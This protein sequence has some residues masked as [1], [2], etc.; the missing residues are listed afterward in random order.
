MRPRLA[1]ERGMTL[2]EVMVTMVI[3]LIMSLATFALVD[4]TIR[5]TSEISD[6]VDGVQRGR[7]VMDLVTRQLRSQV[8]LGA[9]APASRSVV[10]GTPTSV[11]FY[12]DTGDSS[13]K[14]TSAGPS[15]TPT[16]R[17]IERRS[18]TLETTGKYAPGA[19]VERRWIGTPSSA[20][21][22][23][24]FDE[25]NPKIRELAKPVAL[26]KTP[27]NP[28]LPPALFRYYAWNTSGAS[29]TPNLL[30]STPL[31]DADVKRVAKIEIT[32]RAKPR[33]DDKASTVFYTDVALRTVDPN[34]EQG[35]LNVP[36]L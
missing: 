27:N 15:A 12:S 17:K 22:G 16:P 34:A 25:A 4:V 35:E 2:P 7:V 28:T 29:P 21:L 1:D 9:S 8:C 33:K 30:L 3:A 19:I 23:Y 32:F 11:T 10:A 26:T 24:V 36:C 31:S 20:P 6:R 18:L 14:N 13:N 5:Q